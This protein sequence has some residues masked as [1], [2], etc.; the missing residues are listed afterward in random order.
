M[1]KNTYFVNIVLS[2]V[3]VLVCLTGVIARSFFPYIILP[4]MNVLMM[5]AIS[6]LSCAIV[7]YINK[8]YQSECFGGALLA[9]LN[10]S[11]LPLCAG[12][13]FGVPVWKLFITGVVVFFVIDRCY[14][15]IGRRMDTGAYSRLAPLANAL[16]LFLACQ[17]FQNIF[18]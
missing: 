17:C 4:R 8:G 5:A 12:L 6:A 9:G 10:F 7:Y 13:T 14:A 2:I 18:F 3:T 15:S 16:L 1:K 11:V